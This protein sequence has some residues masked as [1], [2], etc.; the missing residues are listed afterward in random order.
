MRLIN[1]IAITIDGMLRNIIRNIIVISVLSLG[2]LTLITGMYLR[3]NVKDYRIRIENV[4]SMPVKNISIM[5]EGSYVAD[6][7]NHKYIQDLL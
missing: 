1:K 7:N 2:I 4:L 6:V 5:M 3:L